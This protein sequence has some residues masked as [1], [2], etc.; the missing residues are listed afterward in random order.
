MLKLAHA[1]AAVGCIIAYLLNQ[2]D[3]ALGIF[4][5]LNYIGFTSNATNS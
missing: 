5:I 4:A 2:D 1:V 3:T